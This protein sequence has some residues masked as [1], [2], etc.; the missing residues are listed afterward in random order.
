MLCEDELR[1]AVLLVLANKQDLPHAMP[2]AEVTDKLGLHTI[3]NRTWHIQAACATTGDGLY[4]G[5]DWLATALSKPT[6]VKMASNGSETKAKAVD[7]RTPGE[8]KNGS[9]PYLAWVGAFWR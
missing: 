4:E 9:Y 3:R 7:K 5:L 6:T 2:V 1:E 8:P